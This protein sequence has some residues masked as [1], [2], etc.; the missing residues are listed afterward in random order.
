MSGP[1]HPSNPLLKS[2]PAPPPSPPPPSNTP[3]PAFALICIHYSLCSLHRQHSHDCWLLLPLPS[4][5][6]NTVNL[7]IAFV[8]GVWEWLSKPPMIRQAYTLAA[9]AVCWWALVQTRPPV[10]YTDRAGSTSK[11]TSLP[12]STSYNLLEYLDCQNPL[13]LLFI[14]LFLGRPS[15]Q[16]FWNPRGHF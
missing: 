1:L 5:P 13:L 15:H 10:G 9:L 7:V 2:L 3:P 14:C 16:G 11:Q 12:C 8:L 6:L 4:S